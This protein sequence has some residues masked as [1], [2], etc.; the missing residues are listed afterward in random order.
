MLVSSRLLR[1]TPLT[2][3][4]FLGVFTTGVITGTVAKGAWPWLM[5]RFGWDL[6]ALREGRLYA[7]WVGLLFASRPGEHPT[8]LSMLLL[9]AGIL[10]YCRGSGVAA[11]GF[12]ILGPLASI[13]TVLLLWPLEIF[14]VSWVKAFLFTPDMGSS[15]ASLVC[16]GLLLGGERGRWRGFV[17]AGTAISLV[18]LLVFL[19]ERYAADHLVSFLTG[20]GVGLALKAARRW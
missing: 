18:L 13:L 16:W 10:E 1:R 5:E 19:P 17:L 6:N 11:A 4:L 8:M 9:G 20:L 7:P 12:F 3:I 15:G 2:V 14:G